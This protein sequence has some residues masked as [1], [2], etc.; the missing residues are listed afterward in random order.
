MPDA[1]LQGL[2]A[3]LS[4]A[5]LRLRAGTDADDQLRSLRRL[6]EPYLNGLSC[7]LLIPLPPWLPEKARADNWQT[8]AF[9][10]AAV[11]ALTSSPSVVTADEGREHF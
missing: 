2:R 5:G 1:D 4:L 10:R 11:A 6:Y 8:S 7:H 3:V 9:D